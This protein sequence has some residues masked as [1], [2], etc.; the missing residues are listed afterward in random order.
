M[1]LL[2]SIE[3]ETGLYTI[4]EVAMYA[5]MPLATLR[6]WTLG[7][8]K[9]HGPLRKPKIGAG[10]KRFLTFL[11]FQEAVVVRFFREEEKVPFWKIREAVQR[12]KREYD[13]EYPF[14]YKLHETS[15][16]GKDFHIY[17]PDEI[18]PV[19][20]TGK[21]AKQRSFGQIVAPYMKKFQFNE[22][23]LPISYLAYQYDTVK[24]GKPI[25]ITMNPSFYFG[26]P[27]V[28]DTGYRALTLWRAYLAE[29]DIERVIR[30]YRVSPEHVRAATDYCEYLGI[31]A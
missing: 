30:Y 26:Q 5:K 9:G 21:G 10:K 11:D 20:L 14:A 8:N 2:E 3:N 6:Y 15:Y 7:D 17:L 16:D 27:I 22:H 4:P 28:G 19:Q 24:A 23:D 29:G 31:A 13:V 18:N 1:R 12:A 25:Q